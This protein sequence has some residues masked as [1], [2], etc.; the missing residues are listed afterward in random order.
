[1]ESTP[2]EPR[3]LRASSRAQSSGRGSG[4]PCG[5]G[6]PGFGFRRRVW[7]W[8]WAWRG[9]AALVDYGIDRGDIVLIGA[10]TGP[11]GRRVAD[12]GARPTPDPRCVVVGC[13]EP[14][15]LGARLAC[16][17]VRD[18]DERQGAI[19]GLRRQRTDRLRTIDLAC[20]RIPIPSDGA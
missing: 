14:A 7:E 17:L 4:S 6:F 16:D 12:P 19:C 3:S 20:A 13:C 1:M 10:L 5:S 9:G 11:G 2:S 18:H 15:C 8:P